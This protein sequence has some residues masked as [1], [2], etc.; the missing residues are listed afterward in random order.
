MLISFAN[1]KLQFSSS[2][3]GAED[4]YTISSED[5]R[6][7]ALRENGF[8]DL[9]A[10]Y[11]ISAY[12]TADG[13]KQSEPATTTLYWDKDN[14]LIETNINSA[15]MR[16]VVVSSDNGLVSISG[17]NEGELVLFYGV[18]GSMLSKQKAL[19][20]TA[21]IETLEKIVIVK[22]GNSI[23]KVLVK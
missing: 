2:T 8:L 23:M 13:Y 16:G 5:M 14:A 4:H 6:I 10:C 3:T 19:S 20:D 21:S 17:L 18:N 12:A 15:K 9:I 11:N 1:G 7:N 22:V